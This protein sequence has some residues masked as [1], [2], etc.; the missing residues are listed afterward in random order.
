MC[1]EPIIIKNF[2]L[3]TKFSITHQ[4]IRVPSSQD[5]TFIGSFFTSVLQKI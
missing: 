2:E 5:S 3:A 4:V 1:D